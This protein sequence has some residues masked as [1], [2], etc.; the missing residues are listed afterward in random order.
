MRKIKVGVIFGGRSG[1]HEVSLVSAGSI[2]NAINREKYEILEIGIT[3]RGWWVVEGF[4]LADL[5]NGTPKNPKPFPPELLLSLDVVF[6][7][8][9]GPFGEDGTIQGLFE[10]LDLPYV[11][12]GVL[13]SSV[14]MDKTTAKKAFHNAGLP[15]V[16]HIALS[17][18]F[19]EKEPNKVLNEIESYLGYPCFV[20]PSALGSSVGITKVK[21]RGDLAPAIKLAFE[22][23][24]RILIEKGVSAREIECSVLGNDE[25][26]VSKPGEIIPGREF[27]DY[28][29]KYIGGKTK[30]VIPAKLPKGIIEE[31]RRIATA[32]FRAIDCA[33]LARVDFLLDKESGKLYLSE[34]NTMPGF[35]PISM[36]PKLLM[37]SGISYPELIDRLIVLG[38]ER[39]KEKSKLRYS[40][41]PPEEWYRKG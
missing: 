35:T 23:D 16:P 31:V 3:K 32:A 11:G 28:Y 24:L 9:H 15:V 5:K 40:I 33:G 12:A 38:I 26:I 20:K 30:F 36:Y 2:I 39:Y 22:F 8:L 41:T 1:E 37:A 7:V 18:H 14:A 27:Y 25:L 13:A 21:G 34:L 17:H 6:P 19:W 4:P 29:D 10:M